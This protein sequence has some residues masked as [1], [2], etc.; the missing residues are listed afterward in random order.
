MYISINYNQDGNKTHMAINIKEK[1][2]M[3]MPEVPEDT[4]SRVE[5]FIWENK[6]PEAKRKETTFK[7]NRICTA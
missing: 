6:Y 7:R 2:I 1:T 3:N 5:I 4:S